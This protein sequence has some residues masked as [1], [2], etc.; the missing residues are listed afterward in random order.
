[1]KIF[2]LIVYLILSLT[3]N[4]AGVMVFVGVHLMML[5]MFVYEDYLLVLLKVVH[6]TTFQFDLI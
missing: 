5:L 1:M 6:M 3:M 2:T 4:R